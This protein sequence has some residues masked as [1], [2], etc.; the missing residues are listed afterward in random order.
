MTSRG[1]AVEFDR[2]HRQRVEGDRASARLLAD[3]GDDGARQPLALAGENAVGEI[4]R[5]QRLAGDDAELR[6]QLLEFVFG[7]RLARAFD[8]PRGQAL[9]GCAA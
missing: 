3:H 2:H 4:A 1:F 5:R 6:D 9:H 7:E 8:D